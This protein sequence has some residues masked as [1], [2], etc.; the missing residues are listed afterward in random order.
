MVRSVI[1]FSIGLQGMSAMSR[2]VVNVIRAEE[3]FHWLRK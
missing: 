2:M 1:R 3:K